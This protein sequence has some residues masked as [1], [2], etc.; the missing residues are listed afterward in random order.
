MTH[1]QIGAALCALGLL[2][3]GWG[4]VFMLWGWRYMQRARLEAARIL[5][6][7]NARAVAIHEDAASRARRLVT[8]AL[9]VAVRLGLPGQ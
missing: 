2:L 9:A 5:D 1:E 7:A 6:D 4:A 8:A 3:T